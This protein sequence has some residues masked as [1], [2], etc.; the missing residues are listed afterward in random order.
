M[1]GTILLAYI[2]RTVVTERVGTHLAS[3]CLETPEHPEASLIKGHPEAP[4]ASDERM[5]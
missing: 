2:K 1:S 5:R 3:R 4:E